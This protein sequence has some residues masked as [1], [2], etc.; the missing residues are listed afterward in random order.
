MVRELPSEFQVT[1]R[2]DQE[3]E[4]VTDGQG[5]L[6]IRQQGAEPA[7]GD[8]EPADLEPAASTR[9]NQAVYDKS[10]SK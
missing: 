7:E 4:E 5:R 1:Y 9:T 6:R 3:R 2:L 8:L 10:K